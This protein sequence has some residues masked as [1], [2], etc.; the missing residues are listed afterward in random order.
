M[1]LE[2]IGLTDLCCPIT[3]VKGEV[4]L[5]DQEN[6]VVTYIVEFL[7]I[8]QLGNIVLKIKQEIELKKGG[9]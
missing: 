7:L 6:T 3:V 5:G 1:M 4:L 2:V 8:L 9:A